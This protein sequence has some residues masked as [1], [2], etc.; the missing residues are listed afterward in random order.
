MKKSL[1]LLMLGF[2]AVTGCTAVVVAPN[3][4]PRYVV[5]DIGYRGNVQAEVYFHGGFYYY[6][7]VSHIE[8]RYHHTRV[9]H[10]NSRSMRVIT[11]QRPRETVVIKEASPRHDTVVIKEQARNR[12]TVIIKEKAPERNTVIIKEKNTPNKIKGHKKDDKGN[13]KNK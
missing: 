7:P 9:S 11:V 8:S 1:F 5:T 4:H 10:Y 13:N 12:D 6:A 2:I 3:P